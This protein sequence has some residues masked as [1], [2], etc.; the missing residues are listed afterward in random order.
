MPETPALPSGWWTT[1]AGVEAVRAKAQSD[2]LRA[3]SADA[4]W[5]TL[6]NDIQDAY[7]LV[8]MGAATSNER[9]TAYFAADRRVQA[10]CQ[11]AGQDIGDLTP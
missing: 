9:L 11:A 4:R 1:A 5:Q 2:A 7:S 3:T 6:Q 8:R 10:D